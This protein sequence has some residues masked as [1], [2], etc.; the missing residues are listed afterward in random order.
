MTMMMSSPER[1]PPRSQLPRR[2]RWPRCSK[3][4]QGMPSSALSPAHGR[5]LLSGTDPRVSSPRAGSR[6]NQTERACPRRR[7]CRSREN[8]H[9]QAPA[10]LPL[11]LLG[12]AA[13]ESAIG[14]VLCARRAQWPAA[15]QGCQR[16][17]P[18]Q[19]KT[20]MTQQMGCLTIHTPNA[21]A[22]LQSSWSALASS[23]G[24]L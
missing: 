1:W 17:R 15:R 5:A 3:M 2:L 22:G 13:T 12:W 10:S 21:V 19:T 6:R 7:C 23:P 20:T 18:V 9:R 11:S 8:Y 4:P 16:R 24:L 14:P